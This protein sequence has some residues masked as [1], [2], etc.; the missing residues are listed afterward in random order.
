VHL[1]HELTYSSWW[2]GLGAGCSFVTNGPLL[3]VTASGQFPGHVFR[4]AAGSEIKLDLRAK[5][6]TQD[7]IRFVEVIR[8][9]QVERRVKSA[10]AQRT[11]SLGTIGFPESGWFLVRA[12]AENQK[13]FRF[14]ST[15]PFYVEIGA[16]QSRISKRSAEFFLD[17]TRERMGRIKL[18]DPGQRQEVLEYHRLAEKFWQARVAMANGE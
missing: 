5:L 6:T 13:T 3:R 11:G 2:Q 4:G 12:I 1:D 18:D 7:P 16:A 14:A 15:A 9:G 10:D 17:W 8:N